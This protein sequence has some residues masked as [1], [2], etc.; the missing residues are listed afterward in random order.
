MQNATIKT[1][2]D[3]CKPLQSDTTRHGLCH[4]ARTQGPLKYTSM[5]KHT[6]AGRQKDKK[7]SSPLSACSEEWWCD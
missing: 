6:H 3:Q 4:L 5:G 7:P 2:R 1:F